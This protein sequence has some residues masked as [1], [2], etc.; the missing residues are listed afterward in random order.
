MKVVHADTPERIDLA[1][2]LF[3][4]YADWLAIDLCFQGFDQELA[5]LPGDYAPPCGRLL[6]ALADDEPVGCVA[7]RP[8]AADTAEL[9]RLYV[10]ENWR[11]RGVGRR[12][13][14]RLLD[15]ARHIGYA[16]VRLDSLPT[17]T[18]ATALYRAVGF[19]PCERYYDTPLAET[20]F[21]ELVLSD[22]P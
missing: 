5:T 20:V 6:L 1:R 15:E 13:V 22:S 21:M 2:Q 9:K 18:S 7:L 11:G 3:L 4:E 12:L 10:Q 14:E 17:M 19:A 16:R 8:L